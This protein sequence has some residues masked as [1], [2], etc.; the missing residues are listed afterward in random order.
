[1]IHN[2]I[3]WFRHHWKELSLIILAILAL[4][5]SPAL[6]RL[7]DPSAGELDGSVFHFA[8]YAGLLFLLGIVLLWIGLSAAFPTANHHIDSGSWAKDFRELAPAHRV[9][10]TLGIIALLLLWLSV[11]M[12]CAHLLSAPPSAS[13]PAAL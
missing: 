12:V 11:C 5:W 1:M 13:Y 7:H 6:Y 2:T 3:H 9:L 8:A 4:L 10:V